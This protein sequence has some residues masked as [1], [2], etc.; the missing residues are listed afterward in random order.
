VSGEPASRSSGTFAAAVLILAACY[1]QPAAERR[2]TDEARYQ[3]LLAAH[4]IAPADDLDPALVVS[5]YDFVLSADEGRY[6][7]CAQFSISRSDVGGYTVLALNGYGEGVS[8]WRLT[9]EE[10]ASGLRIVGSFY[11]PCFYFG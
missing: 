11:S 5:L 3:D 1:G 10:G 7:Q 9:V 4:R 2:A 8:G 6:S